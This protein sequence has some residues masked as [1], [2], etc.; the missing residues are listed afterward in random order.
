MEN[1]TARVIHDEPAELGEGPRYEPSSDTLWWFDIVGRFLLE[2]RFA[3]GETKAHP[4]PFMASV[5]ATIDDGRQ[6]VAS[7]HGLYVRDVASGDLT[8]HTPLEADNP[9]TR[10]NDGGVNPCGALWIGTMGKSAE[11]GAGAIYH[12]RHGAIRQ[13]YANVSVPNAISFTPDGRTAY[14]A[15]TRENLLQRV[16][17]DP[18]TG[19][20]TGEPTIAYDHRGRKGGLDGAVVDRDGNIWIALWG[21]GLVNAYSP[22]GESLRSITVP[23]SLA[24]CP[25]FVGQN[26]DRLIV[27]SARDELSAEQRALEPHAGKTF[28]LDVTVNGWPAPRL[29]LA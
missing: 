10:S 15:D 25:A 24:T 8:L 29:L 7:E 2:H 4:L 1:V 16:P 19:L 21:A 27:T 22:A 17:V 26:S 11:K 12:F 28:V 3:T 9:A 6:L 5:L 13:L 18:A 23:A 20:P 14:F